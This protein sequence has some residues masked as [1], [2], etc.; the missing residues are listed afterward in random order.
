MSLAYEQDTGSPHLR[1]RL[2]PLAGRAVSRSAGPRQVGRHARARSRPRPGHR[3][4]PVRRGAELRHRGP[5]VDE[6]ERAAVRLVPPG[7]GRADRVAARAVALGVRRLTLAAAAVPGTPAPGAAVPR[8]T[9]DE[10]RRP[11]RRRPA[12]QRALPPSSWYWYDWANSAYVTTTATVLFAPYLTA[13]AESRR[14]P[15]LADG[16]PAHRPRRPRAS[17]S[18]PAPWSPFTLT[19]ADDRLGRG[20]DLRRRDRRP[21][22]PAGPA[23][24]RFAVGG[25]RR[26]VRDVPRRRH[27]LAARRPA[28]HRGQPLPRRLAGRLRLAPVPDREPGRAR[29]GLHPRLGPGLP[30][31]RPAARP[32]PRAGQLHDTLGPRQGRRRAGQHALGGPVVGRLHPHPVLGLWRL[33]GTTAT[34]VAR[35]RGRRR[36]QPAPARPRP[37]ASCG[38]YPQTL[39]FLLAYLFFND[40]IQTVIGSSSLYGA[41]Q[42]GFRQTTS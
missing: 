30:R 25:R 23:A 8:F 11:R 20:A 36:R 10:R 4:R 7:L 26:G 24:R 12:G 17:R 38:C 18:P 15:G 19:L 13:V 22:A 6:A 9:H 28:A 5:P 3:R 14:V 39:L 42:L 16:E 31:R 34:P 37:S 40:G 29:P 35:V 32:Q 2:L 41:E 33:R 27:Q 21:V 1:H